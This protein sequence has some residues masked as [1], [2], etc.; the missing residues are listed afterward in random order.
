MQLTKTRHGFTLAEILT[1]VIIVTILTLMA[2]P[3]YEKTIERSHLAEA[4]TIMLKLQEAKLA[5][6]DNM[7]CVLGYQSGSGNYCPAAKQPKLAHLGL[8]FTGGSTKNYSFQTKYFRYS[9]FPSGPT[10]AANYRY[11]NGVCAVRTGGDNDGVMFIYMSDAA[12]RQD[13]HRAGF[14]C[15]DSSG[16]NR[17]EVY[18]METTSGTFTCKDE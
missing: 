2:V 5:A 7:G 13:Y 9:I 8:A 1:A 6:M 17:C 15:I 12:V 16:Q 11:S 10:G 4:R 14:L 3:M 18:G